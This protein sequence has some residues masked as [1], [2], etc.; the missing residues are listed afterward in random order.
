MGRN[1]PI[2]HI[3]P[4]DADFIRSL[5]IH[6]DD[7]ILAFNKPSGLAVQTAGGRGQ[8]VDFLLWAFAKS[9][10][11]RPKLVHR[12][13]SGTSGVLI[14]AR[15]Q[16]AAAALSEQFARRTAR[17]T[18]LAL[19]GGDIPAETSGTMDQAL[20]KVPSDRGG[21]EKMVPSSADTPKAQTAR[22]DWTIIARSGAH[23]LIR[24]K[25]RTGRMHQI[26][27]HMAAL[28]CPILGDRIYGTGKMSADRLMLH[29]QQ[30]ELK[31][32]DGSDLTLEA[33]APPDFLEKASS[34]G[35][36]VA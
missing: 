16:P 11:K 14:V 31:H 13:D 36:E 23:A 19:V 33:G 12:I 1:R 30:L 17:K 3:K 7:Q 22:T 4:E 9:N 29:A 2:P 21:R 26:R 27:A 35:L 6:E 20:L 34:L 8:S 24:A 25:P 5:V 15:T 28:G 32:P 10:G 18:Y